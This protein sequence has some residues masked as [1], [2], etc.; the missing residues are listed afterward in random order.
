MDGEFTLEELRDMIEALKEENK[1]LAEVAQKERRKSIG[2][3]LSGAY[4]ENGERDADT[5]QDEYEEQKLINEAKERL[6]KKF[7]LR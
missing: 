4:S 5:E 6:R 1:R 3:F 7:N 2:E